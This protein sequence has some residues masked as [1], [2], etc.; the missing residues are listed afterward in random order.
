MF[1]HSLAW[2]RTTGDSS[3]TLQTLL[4]PCITCMAKCG[5]QE[6]SWIPSADR[7]FKE[8]KRRLC[9][10]PILSLP[11][12]SLPFTVFTD[13]SDIGLGAVLTQQRGEHYYLIAYARRTLTAAERNYSTK[14]NECL[15]IVW[16][17]NHWRPYLLG[18]AFDIVMDHQSLTWLQ[19]LKEPK[20][21]LARWILALQ[22]YVSKL[23]IDRKN[24]IVTE[25]HG[26]HE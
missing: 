7:A 21:R 10:A 11:D 14:E 18:K 3:K 20:G 22:E 5:K 9:Y 8:L 19:G 13:A 12:S 1:G 4:H 23:T 6:F 2:R 26:S 16:S 24:N 17:V 15:A 25:T